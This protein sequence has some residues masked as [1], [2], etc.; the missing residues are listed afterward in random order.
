MNSKQR[1]FTALKSFKSRPRSLAHV[2]AALAI[3]AA[4]LATAP[5]QALANIVTF[6]YVKSI[7]NPPAPDEQLGLNPSMFSPWATVIL[8]D[9]FDLDD[10][11]FR[12]LIE[13][14]F[15]PA[16]PDTSTPSITQLAFSINGFESLPALSPLFSFA[17]EPFCSPNSPASTTTCDGTFSIDYGLDNVGVVGAGASNLNKKGFDLLINL[18]PPGVKLDVSQGM[19]ELLIQGPPSFSVDSF[20]NACSN[21][22]TPSSSGACPAGSLATVA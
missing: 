19:I 1:A 13:A 15:D 10:G 4:W 20:A 14:K 3:T 17:P 16:P 9:G 18:P 11:L 7:S 12:M 21:G 5:T 8:D 22:A 6:N 2:G